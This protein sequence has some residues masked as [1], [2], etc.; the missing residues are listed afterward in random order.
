[1]T[2]FPEIVLDGSDYRATRPTFFVVHGFSS[3][4]NATWLSNLKD[5]LLEKVT[6]LLPATQQQ[7]NTKKYSIRSGQAGLLL[8]FPECPPQ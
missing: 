4:G 2:S 7:G 5:A 3:D 6:A 8:S 1:V